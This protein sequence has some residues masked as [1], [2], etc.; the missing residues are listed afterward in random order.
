MFLSRLLAVLLLLVSLP[1]LGDDM[2]IH[3]LERTDATGLAPTIRPLL[4]E[5]ATVRAYRGKLIIR[6]TDANLADLQGVLGELSGPPATLQ[7]HLRRSSSR[8]NQQQQA[9]GTVSVDRSGRAGGRITIEKQQ[10]QKERQDHYQIRTLSGH[11][12]TISQG[13]LLAISAGWHGS[14]LLRLDEGIQVRPTLGANGTVTLRIA[15]SFDRL[16]QG[17]AKTQHSAT[18]LRLAPGEWQPMGSITV[19]AQQKERG[20]AQAGQTTET[21]TLPL[22]VMVEKM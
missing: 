14:A 16:E 20:I 8:Q 18:T 12:A 22:E 2:Q 10:H 7:V 5:G 11:P 1:A 19:S 17:E 3:V 6:T 13:T 9:R 21:L 15:Q 4:V